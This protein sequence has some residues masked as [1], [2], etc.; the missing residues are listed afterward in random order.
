MSNLT[1]D[2]L[3]KTESKVE[4]DTNPEGLTVL[5]KE[6]LEEIKPKAPVKDSVAAA[7]EENL[8]ELDAALEAKKAA[9]YEEIVAPV[10]EKMLENED[11]IFQ[12]E[13]RDI[14]A[15]VAEM[16][17]NEVNVEDLKKEP[18]EDGANPLFK[19]EEETDDSRFKF[20]LEELEEDLD[21]EDEDEEEE[22]EDDIM[23]REL[24]EEVVKNVKPI[25]S[26]LDLTKFTIGKK[27]VSVSSFLRE[28][29]GRFH[30]ADWVLYAGK[31]SITMSELGGSEIE[32]FS[33]ANMRGSNRLN[34]LKK[35]Y[36][37]LYKHLTDANKPDKLEAWL[38]TVNF[39]DQQHLMMAAYRATFAH[40]NLMNYICPKCNKPMVKEVPIDDLV[41]YNSEEIK[42]E[43]QTILQQ[44][45]TSTGTYESEL[46]QVSDEYVIGFKA[47]SIYNIIF[48]TAAL[49]QEF[50]EKYSD[51]LG[52]IF[53]IDEFY[54]I[55]MASNQLIPVKL[56]IKGSKFQD[57]VKSKVRAYAEMISILSSDEY[58]EVINAMNNI[59]NKYDV[60]KY[61]QP[62]CKCEHCGA[63]IPEQEMDPQ[64]M[65]F[66][67]HQLPL[68]RT[69]STK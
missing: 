65:L 33:E 20:D 18:E 69:L 8:N 15:G 16:P 51:V 28:S 68:I 6:Q 9:I 57:L 31:R 35:I 52:I 61:V 2:D 67:R 12:E 46:I 63:D 10:E 47:P 27:P 29:E 1:L 58:S 3:K 39:F 55:D 48:E 34:N 40:S 23:M 37:C 13:V 4:I 42:K 44:D 66:T 36:G 59:N 24:K 56:K 25:R 41:K 14:A 11:S 22:S 26:K 62:A 60:V 38:K 17:V 43:F 30:T 64:S 50:Q 19:D 45:T 5:S 7:L 53:Y 32:L 49:P 21:L 54:R